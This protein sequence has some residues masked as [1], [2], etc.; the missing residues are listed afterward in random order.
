MFH[1]SCFWFMSLF[2]KI[3]KRN[4]HNFWTNTLWSYP[5]IAADNKEFA[6]FSFSEV[7][8]EEKI[9]KKLF[10]FSVCHIAKVVKN[11]KCECY[12]Y[13]WFPNFTSRLAVKYLFDFFLFCMKKLKKYYTFCHT[14]ILGSFLYEDIFSQIWQKL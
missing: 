9:C 5:I 3:Q 7:A 4:K 2:C 6:I 14:W 10:K 12:C 8:N 13:Q 1:I 11:T